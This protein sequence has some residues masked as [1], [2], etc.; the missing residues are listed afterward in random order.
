MLA[1][2]DARK[3]VMASHLHPAQPPGDLV[4]T[5]SHEELNNLKDLRLLECQPISVSQRLLKTLS[6]LENTRVSLQ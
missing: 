2:G 4:S 5:P 1:Q 3:L 6:H